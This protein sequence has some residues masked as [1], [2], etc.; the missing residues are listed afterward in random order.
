MCGVKRAS[1]PIVPSVQSHTPLSCLFLLLEHNISDALMHLAQFLTTDS[2]VLLSMV[3]RQLKMLSD[4]SWSYKFAHTIS[5][6]LKDYLFQSVHDYQI[7]YNESKAQ[8]EA[9]YGV[10]TLYEVWKLCT[11]SN[12]R[13]GSTLN[14][15]LGF[16]IPW[17]YVTFLKRV[18][19]DEQVLPLPA[20]FQ[21]DK[22]TFSIV[23][24]IWQIRDHCFRD[25]DF[26]HAS[27][28]KT[29]A[30]SVSLMAKSLQCRMSSIPQECFS[31]WKLSAPFVTI[32]VPLVL[33]LDVHPNF[34][35]TLENIDGFGN[36]VMHHN[37]FATTV[38]D[39]L[40]RR[41][42]SASM[43]VRAVH[44]GIKV[45]TCCNQR[46]THYQSLET[47]DKAFYHLCRMCWDLHYVTN[48]KLVTTYKLRVTANVARQ[49][50]TATQVLFRE[51]GVRP[52][53]PCLLLAYEKE[54]V[55]HAL[56][57]ESW[58]HFIMHNHYTPK[59]YSKYK[60]KGIYRYHWRRSA[61]VD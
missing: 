61:F 6:T 21:N 30:L 53:S 49:L 22:Q 12:M 34:L 59:P 8:L 36:K 20:K 48:N 26:P 24:N 25:V 46:T 60:N 2:L 4:T 52:A 43:R 13:A 15:K 37:P 39:L 1:M 45:C 50:Q 54:S 47:H 23:F 19:G 17:Q 11:Y 31:A 42:V 7:H 58:M 33:C 10:Q 28:S 44:R 14:M 55:A 40:M 56:G 3:N 57:H 51:M 9:Y 18:E 35:E 16:N 38:Y 32:S 41:V 27:A 5:F 29:R